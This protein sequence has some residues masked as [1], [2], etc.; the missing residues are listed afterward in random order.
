ME[1]RGRQSFMMSSFPILKLQ[2]KNRLIMDRKTHLSRYT[3]QN[4]YLTTTKNI[5]NGTFVD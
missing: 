1:A 2:A 5:L 4:N 3:T